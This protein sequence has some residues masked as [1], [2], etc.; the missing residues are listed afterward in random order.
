MRDNTLHIY[1]NLPTFRNT[2]MT[3][4]RALPTRAAGGLVLLGC[5]F[6]DG[7]AAATVSGRVSDTISGAPLSGATVMVQGTS[8]GVQSGA[9]G[10][11]VLDTADHDLTRRK[12]TAWKEG[13]AIGASAMSGGNAEVGL[14]PL[15]PDNP[16]YDFQPAQTCGACHADIHN[17]WQRSSM[18]RATGEKMPQKLSFYLGE[19][20]DGNFDGL[21]FGWKYFAPMMGIS[22]GL[23]ALDLDH[24]VGTCTNCHARGLTWK[25][26]VLEPHKA[27]D[28]DTGRIFIDG[29]L[30]VFRMDRIAQA[31][32]ADGREG[33]TCDVCHSVQDVRIHHDAKGRLSTVDIDRMEIIRRGDVKFGP[34]KDAV[35]TF[36]KSAYSPIFRKSEFCAM[37]HMERADDL[38]ATGVPSMMTLD[39][40]PVWKANFDASRTDRQCQDCHMYAGGHGEWSDTKAAVG[41]VDRDPGELAGH[42]WRGSYFDGEMARRA[43][44]VGLSAQRRGDE[45]LVT[46]TVS[47][48]GAAHKFPGGPPFR[49]VLLLVDAM[50]DS[51][52]ALAPLDPS[53]A[54][55]V[56]AR[57]AN[58]IIDV[59]G[60]YRQNGFFAWWELLNRQPFPQMPYVGHVGKVYN[61]A[62][63][64]P[65]FLPMGWMLSWLW[66]GI[67][68]LAIG[69]LGWSP[70]R[71]LRGAQ[72]APQ[73]M[74]RTVFGTRLRQLLAPNLGPV[75]RWIRLV[76]GLFLLSLTF[77]GPQTA[78]ARSASFHCSL[79][80]TLP[81]CPIVLSDST[82]AVERVPGV[83]SGRRHGRISATR[84]AAGALPP[85]Y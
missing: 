20:T 78:W 82:P 33:L 56:Q 76:G 85:G 39:E 72:P 65:P 41:G 47:N 54:D 77:W 44:N 23:H 7:T 3:L 11:Y 75:D 19:T 35:S 32:V 59:G 58:R 45:L 80:S 38:E 49:Q 43:S 13:Y 17:Q 57:H 40:Y 61:A 67:L 34:F 50:D 27:Y 36:H 21:G 29:A 69:L 4:I 8:L 10:R 1:T 79:P 55:P 5:L 70:W 62:W 16:A 51:G 28:P 12:I 14:T 52:A 81:V 9:D 2:M 6:A 74:R 30:K 48:V 25:K 26:G 60:G 42:H 63:V 18:G 24:Y 46:A 37:C 64:T 68:P 71:A 22:Q 53:R 73:T 31:S 84:N 83:C 66:V 15:P